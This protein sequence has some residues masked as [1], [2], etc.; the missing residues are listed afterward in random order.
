[1]PEGPGQGTGTA[2]HPIGVCPVPSRL[3]CPGTRRDKN[4]TCPAVS[5]LRP[6]EMVWLTNRSVAA[7]NRSASSPGCA[8]LCSAAGARWDHGWPEAPADMVVTGRAVLA[9]DVEAIRLTLC[10]GAVAAVTLPPRWAVAQHHAHRLIR[11][12]DEASRLGAECFAHLKGQENKR[13]ASHPTRR[14]AKAGGA[15]PSRS[16]GGIRS[17]SV[18]MFD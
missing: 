5:R 10:N 8:P 3:K 13:S 14:D 12:R 15:P 1:M 2:G 6:P 17:C 16:V 9:D 4:G 7:P 11:G 18:V